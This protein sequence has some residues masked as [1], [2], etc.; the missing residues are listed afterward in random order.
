MKT[1]ELRRRCLRDVVSA[2]LDPVVYAVQWA[3]D[4][5]CLQRGLGHRRVGASLEAPVCRL[6]R[7]PE[8]DGGF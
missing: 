8:G 5:R 2:T 6:W 4:P 7:R 1:R 3:G